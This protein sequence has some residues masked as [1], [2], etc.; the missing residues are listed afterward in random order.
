MET[1]GIKFQRFAYIYSNFPRVLHQI[2]RGPGLAVRR[3]D[4]SEIITKRFLQI[5]GDPL[6][7]NKSTRRLDSISSSGDF[8]LN[9]SSVLLRYGKL[10]N[11]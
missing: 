4:A 8:F 2:G 6:E 11:N 10:Y 9:E 1:K 3:S 7:G 5:R